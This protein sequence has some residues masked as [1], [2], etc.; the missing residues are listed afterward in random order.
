MPRWPSSGRRLGV[1]LGVGLGGVALGVGLGGVG[2]GLRGR[3]SKVS[4]I[5]LQVEKLED[6]L[7]PEPEPGPEPEPEPEPEPQS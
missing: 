3:V 7:E 5:G 2:L 6:P 4:I 1:G